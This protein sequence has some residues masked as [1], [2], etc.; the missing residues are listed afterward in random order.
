MA[1]RMA[2]RSVETAAERASGGFGA[3]G[4]R[5]VVRTHRS[6][7]PELDSLNRSEAG[8]AKLAPVAPALDRAAQQLRRADAAL[9]RA[10]AK[11]WRT[12]SPEE[13]G[14]PPSLLSLGAQ[15]ETV[16]RAAA[17][18]RAFV[19]SSEPR[20]ALGKQWLVRAADRQGVR[21]R[22]SDWCYAF[23]ALGMDEPE[24]DAHDFNSRVSSFA[25]L[26]KAEGLPIVR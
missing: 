12:M 15:A 13:V 23:I 24:E 5:A 22:A 16:E 6:I 9:A 1:K 4:W 25:G 19:Q 10:I 11:E 8:T 17:D 20:E 18:A 26:G 14:L 3:R 2:W 7:R 21:G